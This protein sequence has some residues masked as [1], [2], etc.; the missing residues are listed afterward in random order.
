M[1]LQQ[2]RWFL[3]LIFANHTLDQY[4]SRVNWSKSPQQIILVPWKKRGRTIIGIST[5]QTYFAI[6]FLIHKLLSHFEPIKFHTRKCNEQK[7]FVWFFRSTNRKIRELPKR[8]VQHTRNRNIS[9]I[10][11]PQYFISI[12][13]QRMDIVR[14]HS[15]AQPIHNVLKHAHTLNRTTHTYTNTHA[16]LCGWMSLYSA[17]CLLRSSFSIPRY[18]CGQITTL[19]FSK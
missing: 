13:L 15:L 16:R 5:T 9:L 11:R 10:P 17:H 3:I 1:L 2:K 14:Y 12:F 8:T 7:I 19:Q 18:M 4:P 6:K